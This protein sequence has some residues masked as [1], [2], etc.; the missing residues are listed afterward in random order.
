MLEKSD[1]C[2]HCSC[3]EKQTLRDIALSNEGKADKFM[4][5]NLINV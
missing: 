5:I 1:L 4:L 2:V 3:K